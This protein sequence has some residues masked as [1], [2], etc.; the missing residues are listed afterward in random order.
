MSVILSTETLGVRFRLFDYRNEHDMSVA[1]RTPEKEIRC[2]QIHWH[3]HNKKACEFANDLIAMGEMI[4]TQIKEDGG[5]GGR[6]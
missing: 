2:V 6:A 5:T 3:P 1:W 4:L